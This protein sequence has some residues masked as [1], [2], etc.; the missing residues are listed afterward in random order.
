MTASNRAIT[1]G[2]A[3]QQKGMTLEVLEEVS[4]GGRIRKVGET[5]EC[6]RSEARRLMAVLNKKLRVRMD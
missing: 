6:T 5:I 1:T 2:H 3:P 4:I